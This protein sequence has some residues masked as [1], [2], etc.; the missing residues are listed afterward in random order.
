MG[1]RIVY[2]ITRWYEK[3]IKLFR[4]SMLPSSNPINRTRG[5]PIMESLPILTEKV[6]KKKI[7][8]EIRGTMNIKK[9]GRVRLKMARSN[10]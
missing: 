3:D 6:G 2:L 5:P 9:I 10:G 4:R 7:H 1:S 8:L